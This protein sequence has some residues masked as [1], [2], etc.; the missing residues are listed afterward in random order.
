MFGKKKKNK[1][2]KD[3]AA[4]QYDVK[5]MPDI[6]Y[7]GKNPTIYEEQAPASKKTTSKNKKNIP[8]KK[9]AP[10]PKKPISPP[11]PSPTGVH[12]DKKKGKINIPKGAKPMPKRKPG[13]FGNKLFVI[14]GIIVIVLALGGIT[15]FYLGQRVEPDTTPPPPTLPVPESSDT[16]ADS[17][18]TLEDEDDTPLEASED[19]DE[20]NTDSSQALGIQFPRIILSDSADIDADQLTDLEEELFKTDSGVWDTDK[21][22]YFDGQ[23]VANLYNPTGFAPVKI[24]DSGL[25]S[26]YINPTWGYRIYYPVSWVIGE[27]DA[28]AS[29]VLISDITGDYV[30]VLVKQKQATET[31]SDWFAREASD[32]FIT[33]IQ[34]KENRFKQSVWKRKDGMVG[35]IVDNTAVYVIIYHPDETDQV[36]FRHVMEMMLQSFRLGSGNIVLPDQPVLP[37]PPA[38]GSDTTTATSSDLGTATSTTLTTTT[39]NE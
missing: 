2:K 24:I 10:V 38:F 14:G 19:T 3:S 27:V 13:L 30:E 4:S 8:E 23:E 16:A 32:Q 18:D 35:F 21:D 7:G 26:E 33:D 6:F 1:E 34:E 20:E 11:V 22:G 39:E 37:K 29:Q 17:T 28:N 5:A 9:I 31:F 12:V 15:W 25:V 36:G